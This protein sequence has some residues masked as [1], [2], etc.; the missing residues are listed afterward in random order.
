MA[1]TNF[2]DFIQPYRESESPAAEVIRDAATRAFAAELA[3]RK[4]VGA[5]LASARHDRGATQQSVADAAGIQ[6]AELS[7]IENGVGNPTVETLLKVLAA[8][9][10][11]LAFTPARKGRN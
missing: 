9:D 1:T 3:E 7:R 4:A 6:Q 5:A 8:L 10:L 11:R 2:E